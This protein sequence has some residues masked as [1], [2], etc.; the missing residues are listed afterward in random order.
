MSIGVS[1]PSINYATVAHRWIR[2]SF[3]SILSN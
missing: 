3:V 1:F 2:L